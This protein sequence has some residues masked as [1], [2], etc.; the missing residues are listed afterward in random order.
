MNNLKVKNDK[1]FKE[2]L[3]KN[4]IFCYS[5]KVMNYLRHRGVRYICKSN[6]ELTNSPFWLYMRTPDVE[7]VMRE[8]RDSLSR[9]VPDIKGF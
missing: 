9:D 1:E 4:F 3:K 8:Y 7:E 2:V 5:P 6:H